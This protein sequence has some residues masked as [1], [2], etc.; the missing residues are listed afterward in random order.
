MKE[1]ESTIFYGILLAFTL[2]LL[3]NGPQFTAMVIGTEP[4][5]VI[6]INRLYEISTNT[7]FSVKGNLN[8]L[9]ISGEFIGN[10]SGIVKIGNLVVIDSKD[11]NQGSGNLITGFVVQN[12]LL[13]N[14]SETTETESEQITEDILEYNES[15]E[16]II[17][18]NEIEKNNNLTTQP[19]PI[20]EVQESNQ[21]ETI[22]EINDIN[23]TDILNQRTNISEDLNSSIDINE[24]INQTINETEIPVEN[25]TTEQNIPENTTQE[26]NKSEDISEQRI[27]FNNYCK[28]TCL[29]SG[30]GQITIIIE[31]Q[32]MR[33]NLTSITYTYEEPEEEMIDEPIIIPPTIN[34]TT[35]QSTNITTNISINLTI[36]QTNISI[37]QSINLTNISSLNYT[38]NQTNTTINLSSNLTNLTGLNITN[39]SFVNL[40]N[41]TLN[42]SVNLTNLTQINLTNTTQN[43]SNIFYEN[44]T[45]IQKF[46]NSLRLFNIIYYDEGYV[47]L[48]YNNN[49]VTINSGNFSKTDIK[50]LELN[51]GRLTSSAIFVN[52]TVSTIFELE[53]ETADVILKCVQFS[54]NT[55]KKWQ[56]TDINYS[57]FNKTTRF[58]VYNDGLYSVGKITPK[59]VTKIPTNSVYYNS[60]CEYCVNKYICDAKIFCVMQNAVD[61]KTTYIGQL[62]FDIFGLN[63]SWYKAEVCAY[64]SYSSEDVINYIKYSPESFCSDINNGN[65]TSDI[66]SYD[67]IDKDSHL[68][69]IDASEILRYSQNQG[70]SNLFVNWIGQDLNGGR[71]PFNCYYGM[72]S[73]TDCGDSETGCKPFLKINYR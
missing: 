62:D 30:D 10:G 18:Q 70:Y 34:E 59:T 5:E 55:C 54:D 69:C 20:D 16:Q 21:T 29:I 44:L 57:F 7:S 41:I 32:D 71:F 58:E 31:L 14:S 4:T 67:V 40:T 51:D 64:K 8:S 46:N 23:N 61:M 48:G 1:V 60:D 6:E 52:N 56:E 25:I 13:D 17:I 36:N 72:T 15:L 37:N 33:L 39:I 28:D 53:T 19:E 11:L 43:I 49:L 3:L 35:N 38:L 27:I 65:S 47:K 73:D 68:V 24:T 22:E 66:I 50:L 45:D 9:K 12:N 26:I 42:Q 2:G 63:G